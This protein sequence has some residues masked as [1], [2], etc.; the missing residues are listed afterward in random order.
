MWKRFNLGNEDRSRKEK[1]WCRKTEENYLTWEIK[2][3]VE[4]RKPDI[5]SYRLFLM[6]KKSEKWFNLGNEDRS[7][8][9]R[10]PDISSY[11]LFYT[12]KLRKKF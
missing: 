3:G 11:S 10:R 2:T 1:D 5:L 7:G 9:K 8:E 6:Q 12:E 4:R